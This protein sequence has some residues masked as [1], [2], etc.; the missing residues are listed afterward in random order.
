MNHRMDRRELLRLGAAAGLAAGLG[1]VTFGQKNTDPVR[2][3]VIGVGGR[4]T[5]LLRLALAAG[6]EVPALC[7]IDQSHLNRGLDVVDPGEMLQAWN[8][9]RLGADVVLTPE[10]AVGLGERL[11]VDAVF[12]GAIEEYG[13]ERLG[14]DKTYNVTAVFG[15]VETVTGSQIWSAQVHADGASL[16]KNLFGGQPVSL[17]EVS[18]RAVRR[19]LD[20]L[21]AGGGSSG[22]DRGDS[23]R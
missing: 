19:S 14:G 13:L 8:D 5:H 1:S 11:G 2:I 9:M 23:S 7:D 17:Y 10:Q 3:G 12:T 21:L 15:L 22:N 4:G 18:R 6:V 16:W 20:T